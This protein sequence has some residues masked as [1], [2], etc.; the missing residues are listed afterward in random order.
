LPAEPARGQ[1]Q[2]WYRAQAKQAA[3]RIVALRRSNGASLFA[4]PGFADSAFGSSR[5]VRVTLFLC[6]P[7]HGKA[8][9]EA[10][11]LQILRAVDQFRFFAS[12]LS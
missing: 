1:A 9:A 4:G 2:W 3:E 7:A 12:L 6:W 11:H 5:A 10:P 8:P